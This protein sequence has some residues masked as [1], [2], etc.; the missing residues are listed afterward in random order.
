MREITLRSAGRAVIRVV[1]INFT[2]V[3]IFSTRKRSKSLR[4]RTAD[5]LKPPALEPAKQ[6]PRRK[7]FPTVSFT[8]SGHSSGGSMA[9]QH[10]LAFSDQISGLGH[11]DAAPYGCSKLQSSSCKYNCACKGDAAVGQM[12]AYAKESAEAGRI[13]ALSHV[14]GAKVWVM[15]GGSDTIV[16]HTVGHSAAALYGRMGADVVFHVV[17]GAEHAFVTDTN[18]SGVCNNCGYRWKCA[19]AP[20][21]LPR[22][23]PRCSTNRGARRLPVAQVLL[24]WSLTL[25]KKRQR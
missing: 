22:S 8:V 20:R 14:R 4:G 6:S 25:K 19:R 23:A 21:S 18:S 12:L 16:N 24:T 13:A 10:Y 3:N 5:A 7:P 1:I 2:P 17:P 11:L 15:S 9:S